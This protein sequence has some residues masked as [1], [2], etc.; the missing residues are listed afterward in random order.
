MLN[1]PGC[2]YNPEVAA[3]TNKPWYLSYAFRNHVK[4]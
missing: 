4:I 2:K 3:A 1:I